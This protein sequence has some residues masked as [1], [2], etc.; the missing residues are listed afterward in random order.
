M[1]VESNIS[2]LK[3]LMSYALK[4]G[5]QGLSVNYVL[6]KVSEIT[7]ARRK[8]LSQLKRVKLWRHVRKS[9][10]LTSEL[11]AEKK[12]GQGHYTTFWSALSQQSG[13]AW[14]GHVNVKHAAAA[15]A[16]GGG[17]DG[18]G[19]TQRGAAVNFHWVNTLPNS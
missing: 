17:G 1:K 8:F 5:L 10:L 18:E 9:L 15:D 19:G 4:L 16:A 7:P 14:S 11:L 6:W 12:S 13:S 3:L 2:V